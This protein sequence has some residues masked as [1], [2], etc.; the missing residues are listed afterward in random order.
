[1]RSISFIAFKEAIAA[2]PV[3]AG[4]ITLSTSKH[5]GIE[6]YEGAGKILIEFKGAEIVVPW[7]NCKSWV[8]EP[9]LE[10]IPKAAKN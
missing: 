9:E 1:M 10:H 5:R 2:P 8:L 6:I 7:T 3:F 4:E